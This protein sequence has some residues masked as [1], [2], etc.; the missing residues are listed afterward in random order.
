MKNFDDKMAVIIGI[1][2]ITCWAMVAMGSDS[3]DLVGQAF[4]GLFGVAVGRT[5]K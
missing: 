3:K 1:V 4:T 2:I 5:L